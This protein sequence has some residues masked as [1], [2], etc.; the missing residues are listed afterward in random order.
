MWR[1]SLGEV[2][3]GASYIGFSHSRGR[4]Y[5]WGVDGVGDAEIVRDGLDG[6]IGS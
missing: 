4:W 2:E 6:E 5:F 3:V 1:E